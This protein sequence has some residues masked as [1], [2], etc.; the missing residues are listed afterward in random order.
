VHFNR[1]PA[2]VPFL[3]LNVWPVFAYDVTTHAKLSDAAATVSIVNNVL[4]TLALTTESLLNVGE[5]TRPNFNKGNAAGWI[6]EG[7][8]REDGESDCDDRVRNH[9][10]NPISNTGYSRLGIITGI[11]SALWGLEDSATASSQDFS[12]RDARGD[13]WD[14]LMASSESARQ[15]NLAL[16]F[17][18]LGQ[19][20]HLVQDAAQPQH[21]RN[22]SHAG[23]VCPT[24]LGLLGPQSLYELYVETNAKVGSLTYSGYPVVDLPQP[25]FFWD[26]EDSRGVAEYSNR[27]FV[28]VGTNFTGTP[29][30]VQPA[31]GFP[32]PN[33]AGSRV[34]QEDIQSLLPG[35]SLTGKMSFIGTPWYDG[36]SG[37]S[38]F[39][40]RTSTFSL[41]TG[42]LGKR[43]VP[44]EY[45][46]NV[47]TYA[48]AQQ[49]L[50]P[51][52]VGYSAGLLNY[53]FR[54]ALS[55][56]PPDRF[57][58]M[59]SPY[60]G[61]GTF[62]KLKLK[63]R[64]D[65]VGAD[66]GSGTLFAIVRY[67]THYLANPLFFPYYSGLNEP[68]YAISKPLEGVALTRDLQPFT[69]DFSDSPIPLNVGD[70]SVMVAFRGPM[71]GAEYTENDAI[72][73]G[74]KDVFEPQL[75][76]FGNSTDYD[77]YQNALYDVVDRTAAQRDLNGDGIQDLFGPSQ[78]T[79]SFV[80]YQSTN[81][82]IVPLSSQ[83]ANYELPGLSWAQYGRFV[84]VQDAE[85]YNFVYSSPDVLDTYSGARSQFLSW[86]TLPRNINRLVERDGKVIH[87]VGGYNAF[88]YRGISTPI[89]VD[90]VNDQVV[91]SQTCMDSMWAMPRPFVEIP[92][93]VP[94]TTD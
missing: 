76:S 62:T 92:G 10:Y 13:L 4:P 26:T 48:N 79:G 36:Y 16:T 53:F 35:S 85:W 46:L 18:S 83:T 15:R 19:V 44:V 8:V 28:T 9:F 2:I 29:D 75:I 6:R 43:G 1:T 7:A 12:F 59:L 71:I 90:M 64:N 51:R 69:F 84:A 30:D 23:L 38:G 25:R 5:V 68:S 87:E 73:F 24:T 93:T 40:N 91:Y 82:R 58:Y 65:T 70:V 81:D 86:W 50:I 78:Q 52:A 14:A 74:G 27:N 17:R 37:A 88:S 60:P 49:L 33:A 66:T 54:G 20:I 34:L 32:S 94:E 89:E 55:I 45:S 22:D 63:V 42:D 77:C 61:D 11:E 47:F 39:N 67:R 72:A 80:R 21:T 41:F 3:L 31:P 57:A 56:A